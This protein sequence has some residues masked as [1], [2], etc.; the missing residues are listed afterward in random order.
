MGTPQ[1]AGV[2]HI[3]IDGPGSLECTHQKVTLKEKRDYYK[4]FEGC[5]KACFPC[6]GLFPW[7]RLRGR[8]MW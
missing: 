7:I 2:R 8:R 4:R 3:P 1:R 6:I 5:W